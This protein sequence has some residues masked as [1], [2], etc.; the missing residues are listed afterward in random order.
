[1]F[2]FVK[3][4][5]SELNIEL[6]SCISLDECQITRPYLLQKHAIENGSAIIFAVPYLSKDALERKNISCYAIA[7]DYH[8]FFS[9]LFEKITNELKAK[10]PQ[11][12][13]TGFTDHSP[14]NEIDA[15]ARCGL[16]VIGKNHLLITKKYSSYVFIGEIITDVSLP[17]F[18]GEKKCCSNCGTCISK[19]P[20][21]M[22]NGECLS[23]ITQKK[24][25]LSDTERHL[26]QK[27]GC[28]WGCDICQEVCPLTQAATKSETIYTNIEFFN[29][30]LTPNLTSHQVEEMSD[31][32]F[33]ERAYSWRGK[34]VILRNLKYLEEKED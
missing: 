34:N 24:G 16:G 31:E 3:K 5:L 2:E 22:R 26:I 33:K 14:I 6:V 9:E 15:A 8:L 13:F 10:Y 27:H 17:S 28:A 21:N 23:A 12:K 18:A 30:T 25:E 4:Q 32:E 11:N 29:S 1:M 20:V 7:R 19:C